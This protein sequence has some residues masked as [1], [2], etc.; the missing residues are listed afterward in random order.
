M[1]VAI[2]MMYLAAKM[3]GS[4]QNWIVWGEKQILREIYKIWLSLYRG[5]SEILYL[6]IRWLR[7]PTGSNHLSLELSPTSTKILS[8]MKPSMKRSNRHSIGYKASLPCLSHPLPKATLLTGTLPGLSSLI[9]ST[10]NAW[11]KSSYRD[12]YLNKTNI[13][14]ASTRSFFTVGT[15]RKNWWL[16]LSNV[17]QRRSSKTKDSFIQLVKNHNLKILPKNQGLDKKASESCRK[18]LTR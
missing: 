7:I 14:R 13:R 5:V 8:D 6:F 17:N 15:R 2:A 3:G 12:W 11:I 4:L 9:L 10:T 16:P 18:G 1:E